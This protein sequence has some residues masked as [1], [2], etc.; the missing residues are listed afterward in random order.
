MLDFEL[1]QWSEWGNSSLRRAD[2]G[3]LWN[4]NLANRRT[5]GNPNCIALGHLSNRDHGLSVQRVTDED[6]G[7][8]E[9][10]FAL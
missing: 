5:L 4:W 6:S 3:P 1:L 10:R 2:A 7:F 8:I 9:H